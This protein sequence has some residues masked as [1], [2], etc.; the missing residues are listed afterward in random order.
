MARQP[1]TY[2]TSQ[3]LQS[4]GRDDCCRMATPPLR[5]SLEKWKTRP[6]IPVSDV[7]AATVML[8][9][10]P[11]VSG[12]RHPRAEISGWNILTL[13]S[14]ALLVA[15]C[16][17]AIP[18]GDAHS[19]ASLYLR[20]RFDWRRRHPQEVA[21]NKESLVVRSCLRRLFLGSRSASDKGNLLEG[22]RRE[23]RVQNS[24][25]A[26]QSAL[27]ELSPASSREVEW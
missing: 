14:I 16:L 25:K 11:Q 7:R 10:R 23:R 9:Q 3:H 6:A 18:T 20:S 17:E 4:D 24:I 1:R 19:S 12:R 13:Q 5:R 21:A 2:L 15:P 27:G 26:K 8:P 22:D